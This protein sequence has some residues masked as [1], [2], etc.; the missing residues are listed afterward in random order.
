MPAAASIASDRRPATR[1]LAVVASRPRRRGP[2]LAVEVV[3][4]VV[5]IGHAELG[6]DR[7]HDLDGVSV[8]DVLRRVG[9]V[10]VVRRADTSSSCCAGSA[11]ISRTR[12]T[13]PAVGPF[14]R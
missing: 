4:V 7:V 3:E 11:R 14:E 10:V 8:V 12:I 9:V 13:A 1:V 2:R 6:A 5:E